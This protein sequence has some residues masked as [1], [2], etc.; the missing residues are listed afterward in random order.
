METCWNN[1]KLDWETFFELLPTLLKENGQFIEFGQEP[2][3][4]PFIA[5]RARIGNSDRWILTD[6]GEDS[7]A[8]VMECSKTTKG[9]VEDFKDWLNDN[10]LWDWYE[11]A[12]WVGQHIFQN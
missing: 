3:S 4:T 12:V 2:D 10:W 9:Y 1:G 7:T 11:D 5:S 6:S 8:F